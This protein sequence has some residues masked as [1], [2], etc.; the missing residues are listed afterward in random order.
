VAADAGEFSIQQRDVDLHH[1]GQN[2]L[3]GEGI[4]AEE[5][6]VLKYIVAEVAGCLYV[7]AEAFEALSLPGRV[8]VTEAAGVA[9]GGVR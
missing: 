5:V 6:A 1:F 4:N 8:H 3:V 9:G 2:V 7:G